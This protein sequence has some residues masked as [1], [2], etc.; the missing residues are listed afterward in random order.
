MG[1]TFGKHWPQ[2]CG[3]ETRWPICKLAIIKP[4]RAY[5]TLRSGGH[6][7]TAI[8]LMVLIKIKQLVTNEFVGRVYPKGIKAIA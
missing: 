2:C 4:Y 6:Y 8:K 7:F 3:K 1:L 5:A